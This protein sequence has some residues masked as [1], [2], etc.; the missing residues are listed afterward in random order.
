[1]HL[2]N[3]DKLVAIVIGSLGGGGRERI[4][5]DIVKCLVLANYRVDLVLFKLAGELLRQ[6]PRGVNVHVIGKKNGLDKSIESTVQHVNVNWMCP[7][8]RNKISFSDFFNYVLVNWPYRLLKKF[9]HPRRQIVFNAYGFS[10]YLIQNKPDCV[11]AMHIPEIFVV[12]IGKEISGLECPIIWSV[13]GRITPIAR[14]RSKNFK[15]LIQ[16]ANWVHSVSIRLKQDICEQSCFPAN[17]VT[18]IYNFLDSQRV[19]QLA[20]SPTN[21]PWFDRKE[22]FGHK[23]ILAVGRLIMVKNFELL[24]RS[25]TR[26]KQHENLKLVI[27]GGGGLRHSLQSQV[28][29]NGLS[30]VVSMPGW[31]LNPYAFIRCADVFVLSSKW[32]GFPMVLIEALACGCKVVSTNCSTSPKQIL[33]H[34]RFGGLVP[35][36]DEEA[37]SDAINNALASVRDRE[38]LVNRALEFSPENFLIQFDQLIGD[39]IATIRK[40]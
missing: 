36:D 26:L 37:M 22:A 31:T 19:L 4:C 34:G 30:H 20:S 32:E 23:I 13:H 40:D 25:F 35:V 28:N 3:T 15:T 11:F 6:I 14:S 10:R 24:I 12:L 1:M 9:P 27:L 8:L 16:K 33:D 7:G 5:V 38:Q 29:E 21:H 39:A 17:R 18:V 2:T